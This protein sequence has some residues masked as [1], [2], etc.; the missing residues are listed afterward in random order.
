[1]FAIAL[2]DERS[3]QLRLYRDHCGIKPLYY[4]WDGHQ[5]AFA[6]ELGALEA[7][8]LSSGLQTSPTA[9]WDFLTYRYVPSPKSLY[10]DVFKLP[11]AHRLILDLETRAFVAK[12][13]Y[14]QVDDVVNT[15]RDIDPD[16]ASEEVRSLIT[17]SVADQTIAD[18]PVGF[19][20][21]GG[22]DSSVVVAAAA[23][24]HQHLKTFTIGF[25]P[26]GHDEIPFARLVA[27]RFG[28]DHVETIYPRTVPGEFARLRDWFA[29]PFGDTSAFPTFC[30]SEAARASVTVA[31]TGDGGDEL[32]GGYRWYG[33]FSWM[34]HLAHGFAGS[35]CGWLDSVKRSWARSS[36][37]RR[38]A[39]LMA[40]VGDD[41]LAL[42]TRLMGGMTRAE[43]RPYQDLLEIPDDYDDYWF[44][45]RYWRHDLDLMTRLQVLDFHTF[46]PE[47]IL[48][49]VDR[50]S[51]ANSL[52]VRVPLL[53]RR[54]VEYAFSLSSKTRCPSGKPKG[55][56][57]KAFRSHLPEAVLRRGK[58]GF[59]TPPDYVPGGRAKRIQEVVLAELFDVQP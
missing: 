57:K 35:L 11:P 46:L 26:R 20:L 54:L 58:R 56:L 53:S 52:E 6:S 45:R 10:N 32:F 13:P 42:Y 14:W 12:G 59:S 31:L 47:D 1:M 5:L 33:Q 50:T 44:F 37:A 39:N 9:L 4:Y 8:R 25:E 55:L 28:T 23:Q 7:L 21:S 22:V 17:K 30:V 19:F 24:A 18:V 51:M 2:L 29:E 48:T 27:Q 3:G 16:R 34:R 38:A 40:V 43:K 49:K 15:A 36:L 41:D